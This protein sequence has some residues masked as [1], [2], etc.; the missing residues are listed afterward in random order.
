MAQNKTVVDE[1]LQ[2]EVVEESIPSTHVRGVTLMVI[3]VTL[4]IA[5]L[6]WAQAVIIPVVLSILISY[7]LDPLHRWVI[8]LGLSRGISAALVLLLVTGFLVGSGFALRRQA[9]D[10]VAG[11]PKATQKVRQMARELRGQGGPVETVK[12]AADDLK[13]AADEAV[14]PSNRAVPKVQIEEPILGTDLLWQGSVGAIELA[15]QVTVVLFLVYYALASGDLYKRRVVSIAG[16]AFAQ[17]RLTVEIMNQIAQQIEGFLVARL[18]LSV[19]VGVATGLA[20]WG[21]GVSQPAMWGVAA[22]VLNNVPYLGP[23]IVAA[24]A[25]LSALVQFDSAYM[26]FV[27]GGVS[28]LIACIEGAVLAPWLLGRAGR[29]EPG[30]VFLGLTL[31]G[32]LWGIWGLLLAVP[33]MIV[34]KAVCDHVDGCDAISELLRD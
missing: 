31:F 15:S 29:M 5:T 34:V 14:P 27:V 12:Q 9:S 33:I 28:V 1:P 25:W 2:D 4:V 23:A 18:L 21:M 19:M 10:F 13:R 8:S 6:W 11:V 3:A 32:W 22:G 16:P 26:A 30:I 7:A 17:K 20:F 24:A